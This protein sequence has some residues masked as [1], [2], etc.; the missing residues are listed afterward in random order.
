MGLLGI[1]GLI[2]LVTPADEIALDTL[3]GKYGMKPFL[4]L[5]IGAALVYLAVTGKADRLLK[6]VFGKS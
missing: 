3:K 6:S 2:S 4:M 1:A 5:G